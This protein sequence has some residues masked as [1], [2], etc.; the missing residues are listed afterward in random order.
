MALVLF[1]RVG[2]NHHEDSDTVWLLRNPWFEVHLSSLQRWVLLSTTTSQTVHVKVFE[3]LGKCNQW[4][5]EW[6]LIE[7]FLH[8]TLIVEWN[9]LENSAALFRQARVQST[10]RVVTDVSRNDTLSCKYTSLCTDSGGHQ[11]S[12]CTHCLCSVSV[13]MCVP[14]SVSETEWQCIFFSPKMK[15]VFLPVQEKK[16][17]TCWEVAIFHSCSK[18]HFCWNDTGYS[19]TFLSSCN[20]TR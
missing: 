1:L 7:S 5:A 2:L 16:K 10:C 14:P 11:Q 17:P 15:I 8:G 3:H 12:G 4:F 18:W 9:G 20:A 19:V 13:L 6:F